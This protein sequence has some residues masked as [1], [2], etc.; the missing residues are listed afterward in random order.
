MRVRLVANRACKRDYGKVALNHEVRGKLKTALDYALTFAQAKDFVIQLAPDF[1][2]P[3]K[4]SI[5]DDVVLLNQK[6]FVVVEGRRK[7][8]TFTNN[9]ILVPDFVDAA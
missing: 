5:E 1:R 3:Q 6:P 4:T 2:R 9:F 8:R 7:V